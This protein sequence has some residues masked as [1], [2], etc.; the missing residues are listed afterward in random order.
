M[1]LAPNSVDHCPWRF[2]QRSHA[3]ILDQQHCLLNLKCELVRP[4]SIHV[5]NPPHDGFS[6]RIRAMSLMP[7]GFA[8]SWGTVSG[9]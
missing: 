9:K 2:V 8:G 3:S 7:V 4:V 5:R 6:G 1:Y